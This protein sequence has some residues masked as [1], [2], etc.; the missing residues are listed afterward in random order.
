MEAHNLQNNS[1]WKDKAI[2]L[3]GQVSP[4]LK[5]YW[6]VKIVLAALV[7]LCVAFGSLFYVTSQDRTTLIETFILEYSAVA[8]AQREFTAKSEKLFSDT[9]ST[10]GTTPAHARVLALRALAADIVANL[11]SMTS[12]TFR[13]QQARNTYQESLE[14]FM[15]VARAYDGSRSAFREVFNAAQ[16]ASNMGGKLRFSVER[17]TGSIWRAFWGTLF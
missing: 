1:G 13:I 8:D 6:T 3:W 5:I 17:F 16:N 2:Q 10:T 7:A 15:G 11:G 9:L 4:A 12:P 14:Q